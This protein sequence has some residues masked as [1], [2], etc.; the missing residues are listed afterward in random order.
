MK[1]EF[2]IGVVGVCGSGKSS[3]VDGLAAHGYIVRHIAQEHSYVPDM[4]QRLTNP[5]ILIYLQ[6]SY[7]NTLK[8]KNFRWTEQEYQEQ[9]RRIQHAID[10]ADIIIKTDQYSPDEILQIV[11]DQL[12]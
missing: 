1:E 7:A 8:R 11:L 2:I 12:N 9:I 4:W 5:A 10:H 3:L 6:V